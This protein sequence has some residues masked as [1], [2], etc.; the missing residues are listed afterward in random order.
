[1]M[2]NKAVMP[3]LNSGNVIFCTVNEYD[4]YITKRTFESELLYGKWI[5]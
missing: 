4:N 3:V 2:C 1:M 5:V